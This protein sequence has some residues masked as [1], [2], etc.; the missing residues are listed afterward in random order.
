MQ[1][2]ASLQNPTHPETKTALDSNCLDTVK[3][4]VDYY[5][6]HHLH[7]PVFSSPIFNTALSP[8]QAIG[9]CRQFPT[10]PLV[11]ANFVL[12]SRELASGICLNSILCEQ[13]FF[14]FPCFTSLLF[15]SSKS[16]ELHQ[17]A[18]GHALLARI[19]VKPTTEAHG[20]R[21]PS[22]VQSCRVNNLTHTQVTSNLLRAV[23]GMCKCSI[24]R[25]NS[26]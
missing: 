22:R 8:H 23:A 16:S 5:L 7:L 21:E 11:E 18:I 9:S 12:A 3:L 20:G 24:H 15:E 17:V 13:C 19:P 14:H 6:A 2:G 1:L 25:C 10:S 26:L 4:D